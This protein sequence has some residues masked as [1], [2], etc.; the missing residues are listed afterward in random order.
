LCGP[1]GAGAAAWVA[2]DD[3]IMEGLPGNDEPPW[4]AGSMPNPPA[5]ASIGLSVVMV[6]GRKF[7]SMDLDA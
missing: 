2:G 7:R 4:E 1:A 5:R 3:D 6:K